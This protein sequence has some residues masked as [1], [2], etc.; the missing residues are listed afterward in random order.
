MPHETVFYLSGQNNPF[1]YCNSFYITILIFLQTFFCA[2][3][4]MTY[5][6]YLVCLKHSL[7][8]NVIKTS[9]CNS[10]CKTQGTYGRNIRPILIQ[11]RTGKK[12]NGKKFSLFDKSLGCPPLGTPR[13]PTKNGQLSD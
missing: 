8:D 4:Y 7:H 1:H 5:L 2:S 13:G 10:H 12:E 3:L 9:I 11:Q 6:L